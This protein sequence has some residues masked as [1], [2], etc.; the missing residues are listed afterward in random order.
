[1]VCSFPPS[2]G[3]SLVNESAVAGFSNSEY[4]RLTTAMPLSVTK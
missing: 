2:V 1:M 4:S 3:H